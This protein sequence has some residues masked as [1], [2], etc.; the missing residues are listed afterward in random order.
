MK[1]KHIIY[2]IGV[3][4]GG[5][6][7]T[8]NVGAL[9][10]QENTDIYFSFNPTIG[11]SLSSA[12][13]S[14]PNLTPGNAAKSSNMT[15]TVTS[16]NVYGYKLLMSVGDGQTYTDNSLKNG[17]NSFTSL[18]LNAGTA[19]LSMGD[20]TWG[21]TTDGT[22][23]S[24]IPYFTATPVVLANTNAAGNGTTNLAIGAK[25][26]ST[27]VPGEYTNVINFALV[28]NISADTINKVTMM[29]D[30]GAMSAAD[31][32]SV[33]SSMTPGAAYT[34]TDSRDG[35]KYTVA[36]LADGKVWMLDNLALDLTDSNVLN[37][38][39]E[40][41][42][43]ASSL[44]L[45]SLKSGNRAAGDQY[46]TA[47]VSNWTSVSSYSAPLVNAAS[48]DQTQPLAAGQSGTGKIG[49]YY[50]YCAASAGSYCYGNGISSGSPSGNA[51]E[52]I[53]PKGWRMPTDGSSGEYQALYAAYSSNKAN[54]VNALKTP[55]S[56]TFNNG[57]AHY[58]GSDGYFWSSTYRSA[59][60]MHLLYVS[61][62]YI[63][64]Q[65]N[66]SRLSGS[67]VRCLFGA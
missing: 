22:N 18:A 51:A 26:A 4:L 17:A 66:G 2:G 49:V 13:I 8:G 23:F 63:S 52:D 48:K 47:G 42:T 5:F 31:Q 6:L 7:S 19:L 14:I 36:K 37:N 65:D 34:L 44:S 43:N 10:A 16:N 41:N 64:P 39:S 12:S 60:N 59:A 11:L 58:Q 20:N 9:S 54:F 33:L 21:Y 29:Q 30:F 56:G 35:T 45:I 61:S 46:A 50:N 1:V 15:V 62:S 57:S 55:L 53:C 27:Q 24:G 25:A 40:Q 67:S 38:L 3:I 32:A 28:G